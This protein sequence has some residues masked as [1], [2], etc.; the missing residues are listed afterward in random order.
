MALTSQEGFESIVDPSFE[1]SFP[2]DSLARVA[3]IVP[4]S[5]PR[6]WGLSRS[7]SLIQTELRIA[8]QLVPGF[9]A[10]LFL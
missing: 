5:S 10:R 6:D 7:F 2:L 1:P 3:A 8:V 9:E 4:E